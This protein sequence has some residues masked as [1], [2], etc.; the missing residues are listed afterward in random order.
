MEVSRV[1]VI[2]DTVMSTE[3]ERHVLVRQTLIV[4]IHVMISKC[5]P[6]LKFNMVLSFCQKYVFG[7]IV[8]AISGDTNRHFTDL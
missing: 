1:P 3:M 6:T 4:P 2:P 7:V 8:K 5:R